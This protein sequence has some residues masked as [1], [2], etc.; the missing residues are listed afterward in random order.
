VGHCCGF[1]IIPFL[2]VSPEAKIYPCFSFAD[3]THNIGKIKQKCIAIT[4]KTGSG[5]GTA[6]NDAVSLSHKRCR[7]RSMM[8]TFQLY[9]A[10]G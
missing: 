6:L 8:V 9:H 7:P 1:T 4:F 10:D 5:Y 2:S 3:L